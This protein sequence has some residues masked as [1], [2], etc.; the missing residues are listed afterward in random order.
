MTHQSLQAPYAPHL[1]E[2]L[3]A[4]LGHTGS[5]T[6]EPWPQYDE[7]LLV[8]VSGGAA[9]PE[10][11]VLV[12]RA[13]AV[14]LSRLTPGSSNTLCQCLTPGSSD[15]QLMQRTPPG[16]ARSSRSCWHACLTVTSP[17]GSLSHWQHQALPCIV[18][19]KKWLLQTRPH[20]L[21]AG[22]RAGSSQNR[23]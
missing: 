14:C 17:H 2:E 22:H 19:T 8:Q 9:A 20:L 1:A 10:C 16:A 18:H 23:M 4:K 3:W 6:Y 11:L 21:C 15:T 13:A 7:A 12:L 5:L